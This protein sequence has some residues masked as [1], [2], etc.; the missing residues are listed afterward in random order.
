MPGI[1]KEHFAHVQMYTLVNFRVLPIAVSQNFPLKNSL[2]EFIETYDPI[3]NIKILLVKHL[4]ESPL[5]KKTGD[6]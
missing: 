4:Q 5:L 3:S 2:I 6:I 1:T